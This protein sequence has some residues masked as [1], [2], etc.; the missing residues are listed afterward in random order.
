MEANTISIQD[1]MNIANDNLVEIKYD[2]VVQS[3]YFHYTDVQGNAHEVWFEDA[4]S[5]QA[6][7][8]TVNEYGIRGLSI[9]GLGYPFP[10]LWPL[11][12]ANFD[13]KKY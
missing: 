12:D 7:F 3:P 9:W 10:Q 13:V 6:K 11:L 1:A 2:Y 5:A 8:N 4:R